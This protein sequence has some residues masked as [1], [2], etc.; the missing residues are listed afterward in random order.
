MPYASID[1]I[2]NYLSESYFGRTDDPRKVSGRALGTFVELITYY[3]LKQ[4]GFQKSLAIETCL[5]EYGVSHLTHNVEF[6]LHKVIHNSGEIKF[7]TTRSLTSAAI[8]K[9]GH[10]SE[11]KNFKAVSPKNLVSSA[12]DIRKLKSSLEILSR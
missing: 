4:W 1:A 2:Q 8:V 9:A 12:L 5:P 6:T 11:L 3:L 10:L 7:N